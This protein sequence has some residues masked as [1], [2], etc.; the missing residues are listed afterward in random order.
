MLF[1]EPAPAA[2]A[3]FRQIPPPQQQQQQQQIVTT[4]GM[5][6]PPQQPIPASVT[7]A[8]AAVVVT[9]PNNKPTPTLMTTAAFAQ[10][11]F[12]STKLKTNSKRSHRQM[13]PT[14]FSNYIKHKQQL[15]AGREQGEYKSVN[16]RPINFGN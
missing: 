7:A 6:T 2:L 11:K 15:Q 8:A 13:S 16:S 9:T 10:T 4:N 14:E 12:G 3:Y 5:T 1:I